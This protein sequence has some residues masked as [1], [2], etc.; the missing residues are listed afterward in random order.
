MAT[1]EL[2]KNKKSSTLTLTDVCDAYKV[3][4][5]QKNLL[6]A[7]KHAQPLN[8]NAADV[9]RIDTVFTQTLI[10]GSLAFAESELGYTFKSISDESKNT[11]ARL[12]AN[13]LLNIETEQ[14]V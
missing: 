3:E 2:R 10:A 6:D 9:T 4:E 13:H 12:G 7:L 1:M 8:I 11:I 5:L 14:T